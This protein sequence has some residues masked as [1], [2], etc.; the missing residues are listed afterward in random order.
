VNFEILEGG[1][2]MRKRK[3]E[4]GFTLIEV[5]VVVAVIAILA[6]ILTPYITKYIEDSKIAKAKNETQ[7]VAAAVVNAMKDL[8]RWPN[9]RTAAANYP[10]LYTGTTA[11][12]AAL[13]T[14]AGWPGAGGNNWNQLDTHLVTNGHT[15][16]A[17]GDTAWKGP[18]ATSL[19]ADPW[20]RP[21]VINATNFQTPPNPVWII[22]AGSNGLV[23]TAAGAAVLAGDD[24]GFRIQ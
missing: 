7:V 5:V 3:K 23:D 14:G 20:G 15:Y 13:F 2:P 22:S 8:G 18:Y 6:A 9:R 16:P 21:Y 4:E 11:P 17:T 10:G 24:I 19:P 12:A 1:K